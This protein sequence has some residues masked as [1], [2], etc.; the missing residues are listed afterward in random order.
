MPAALQHLCV[1]SRQTAEDLITTS[2]W[3]QSMLCWLKGEEHQHW[4]T[5][6]FKWAGLNCQGPCRGP[7][8]LFST[9]LG[10]LPIGKGE[11]TAKMSEL[12][13]TLKKLWR[14]VCTFLHGSIITCW[15]SNDL[16]TLVLLSLQTQILLLY[17]F[18]LEKLTWIIDQFSVC[19]CDEWLTSSQ[20][21][22]WVIYKP[23][24]LPCCVSIIKYQSF[25]RV[26]FSFTVQVYL[27]Y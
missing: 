26:K 17:R 6:G 5:N 15:H 27:F 4:G 14:K 1:W 20:H 13:I 19:V 18:R 24:W 8:G 10:M 21:V 12:T 7:L 22:P 25:R 23:H 9:W 2:V 3:E 16:D 11:Y